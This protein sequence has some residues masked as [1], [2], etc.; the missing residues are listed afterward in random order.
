MGDYLYFFVALAGLAILIGEVHDER[1]T[2][3]GV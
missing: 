3:V 1:P 2:D